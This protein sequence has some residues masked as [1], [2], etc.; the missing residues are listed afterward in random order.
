MSKL[1]PNKSK[2]AGAILVIFGGLT[3][4]FGPWGKW[5]LFI[6]G[7]M[8]ALGILLFVYADSLTKKSSKME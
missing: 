4:R 7:L 3:V 1:T 8:I 6:G 5:E 2:I